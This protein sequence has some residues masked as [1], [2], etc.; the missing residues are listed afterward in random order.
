MRIIALAFFA[1]IGITF[2]SGRLIGADT[3]TWTP[4]VTHTVPITRVDSCARCTSIQDHL[5]FSCKPEQDHCEEFV[6]VVLPAAV[7]EFCE[8]INACPPTK[9]GYW[10]GLIG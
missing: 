4:N 8:K 6:K 2:A 9:K 1:I 7:D 3:K 10:F 5:S